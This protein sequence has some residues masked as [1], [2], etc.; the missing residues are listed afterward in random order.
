MKKMIGI[1]LI[2]TALCGVAGEYFTMNM[3]RNGTAVT[4]TQ[5]NSSW[6]LSAVAIKFGDT[7]PVATQ[8][9]RVSRVSCDME[10]IIGA[11]QE[12]GQS[13]VLAVPEDMA[14]K[15]GDIVKVYGGGATGVVQVF[16]TVK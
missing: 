4:N 1:A 3:G 15:F 5:Q 10:V 14:F 13:M 12:F 9:V 2:V 6:D 7:L 16:T 11:T 8:T